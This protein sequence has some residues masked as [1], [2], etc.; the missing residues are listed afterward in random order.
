VAVTKKHTP[1]ASRRNEGET[2]VASHGV[3]SFYT[4]AE[5][6]GMVGGGIAKVKLDVVQ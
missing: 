2:Q 4:A 1:F 3:A 5:T 6:L